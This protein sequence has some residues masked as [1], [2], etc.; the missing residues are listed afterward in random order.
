MTKK[1]KRT[2]LNTW[3]S[4]EGDKLQIHNQCMY[5]RKKGWGYKLKRIPKHD[6]CFPNKTMAIK[7]ARKYMEKELK[8]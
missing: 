3:H 7:F 4:E 2:G 6:K 1:W 8:K 5:A